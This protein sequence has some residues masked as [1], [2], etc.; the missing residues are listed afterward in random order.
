MQELSIWEI[1]LILRVPVARKM[2]Y[3]YIFKLRNVG[4]YVFIY[5]SML[6]HICDINYGTEYLAALK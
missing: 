6:S 2:E 1:V 5:F 3:E 4:L